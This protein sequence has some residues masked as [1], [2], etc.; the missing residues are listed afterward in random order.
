MRFNR[1]TSHVQ[2]SDDGKSWIHSPTGRTYPY[3]TAAERKVQLLFAL[4]GVPPLDLKRF[5]VGTKYTI[6]TAEGHKLVAEIPD[7]STNTLTRAVS[8]LL[9]QPKEQNGTEPPAE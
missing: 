9:N 1:G 3:S 6:R 4:A 2:P 5:S 8:Q 7:D